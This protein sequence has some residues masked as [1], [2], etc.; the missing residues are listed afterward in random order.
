MVRIGIIG[1]GKIGQTIYHMLKNTD[2]WHT[3]EVGRA[4]SYRIK[5]DDSCLEIAD[6]LDPKDSK[7]KK[8]LDAQGILEGYKKV[9]ATN[10]SSLTKFIKDKTIIVASTPYQ[11]NKK[12]AQHCQENEI[13]YFDLTEDVETT[14][15]IKKLAKK[16]K[17]P[18]MPQCGLAP[19]AIN[20]VAHHLAKEFE[21]IKSIE[22]RVG[23]L[24]L[25]PSNQ[26]KYYL[27][28]STAGL[29]NEYCNP[30]DAIWNG[31]QVKTIPLEGLEELTI[32][33]DKYEAFNTSGGV[34]TLCETYADKVENLTYK[35]LRYPGHRNLI[36][37]LMDDLNL[38]NRKNLLTEIFDQHVPSTTQDVV[39]IY[40]NVVGEINGNLVQKNYVKKIYG[41]KI[42]GHPFSAIQMAT[43][44]GIVPMVIGYAK[45]KDYKLEKVFKGFVKQDEI[46]FSWFSNMQWGNI[47]AEE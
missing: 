38:K 29:I 47:Y 9:N 25:Y 17:V 14:E 42:D 43:A 23:A 15:F 41:Q 30:C 33:G 45:V 35:T 28:W 13:A 2:L 19:G 20:I 1:A 40:V 12:I 11:L 7:V 21:K 10:V 32:D 8:N 46:D 16:S 31:H 3:E 24:P 39:V 26:M 44:S 36:K 37:F 34:S 4:F 5:D 27:S 18:M 22:L 6:I